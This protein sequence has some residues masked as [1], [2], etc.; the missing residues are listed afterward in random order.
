MALAWGECPK[1]LG[2]KSP[3]IAGLFLRVVL[4]HHH[5]R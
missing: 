3:A 5:K 1:S 2:Q 4:C